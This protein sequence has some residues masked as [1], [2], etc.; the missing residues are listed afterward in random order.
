M[1]KRKINISVESFMVIILMII[2][3]ASVCVLIFQGSTTYRKIITNKN[4]EEN[5]RIALSYVN[6]RIKQNDVIDHIHVENNATLNQDVLVINHHGEEEGLRSFIYFDDGFLWECYTD[7]ELDPGLSSQIIPL[8]S[9]EF[10]LS[11][12]KRQIIT[13]IAYTHNGISIPMVQYATLRSY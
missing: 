13:T 10:S 7:G 9:L 5:A 12:N 4:N 11:E 8:E 1:T 6:M 3:A 2:F